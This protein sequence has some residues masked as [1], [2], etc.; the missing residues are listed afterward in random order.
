VTLDEAQL[1]AW[2][3]RIGAG[4]QPPL[5]I[6][7]TGDLG[8]GKSVLARAIARGAGVDATMPSPTFNLVFRYEGAR[9]HVVHMDLYRLEREQDVWE[10]GWREL[11]ADDEIALVEWAERAA[12]LLPA[13][14]WEIMLDV[15]DAHTR[16]VTLH[17]HGDVPALPEPA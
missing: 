9:A 3:E 7:L 15:A 8:A 5:F 2:G 12:S 6:A 14:R 10:L 16:R 11:P 17:R 1:N 4:V 13:D